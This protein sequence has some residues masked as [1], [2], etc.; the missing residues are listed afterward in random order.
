MVGS[1]L[2][3]FAAIV[4]VAGLAVFL[5]SSNTSSIV[6]S[7]FDGFAGSLKAAMGH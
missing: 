4:A 7:I 5:G 2:G 6:K 1:V 3:I